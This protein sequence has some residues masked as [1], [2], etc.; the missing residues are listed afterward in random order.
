MVLKS[1]VLVLKKNSMILKSL[2][3]LSFLLGLCMTSFCQT[4]EQNLMKYWR[5]RGQLGQFILRGDGVVGSSTHGSYLPASVR[6]EVG[7]PGGYLLGQ[8][9]DII[10]DFWATNWPNLVHD[11]TDATCGGL[12]FGPDCT[13]YLGWYIGV[14]ATEY[15]LRMNY[16]TGI[17][18]Q[19]ILEE[20]WNALAA[21]ERLDRLAETLTGHPPSFNGYFLRDD[22]IFDI[23]TRDDN[24]DGEPNFPGIGCGIGSFEFKIGKG[25][26]QYNNFPS[27][28]YDVSI[29]DEKDYDNT[30]SG[31]QVKGLLMG[32][33]LVKA[34]VNPEATVNGESV[35]LKAQNIAHKIGKYAKEHD[36]IMKNANGE[37]QNDGSCNRSHLMMI[38]FPLAE[39]VN[40][41][42]ENNNQDLDLNQDGIP[43]DALQNYHDDLI[44]GLGAPGFEPSTRGLWKTI[45]GEMLTQYSIYFSDP[46]GD[47]P[48][49]GYLT[50]L[51]LIGP[52]GSVVI[53]AIVEA[54]SEDHQNIFYNSGWSL[55]EPAHLNA[56]FQMAAISNKWV[57]DEFRDAAHEVGMEIYPLLSDV[58]YN[59]DNM[60]SSCKQKCKQMIEIAPCDAF[61]DCNPNSDNCTETS[62]ACG[63]L[64]YV[65]V[66][67]WMSENRYEHKN[68]VNG[69]GNGQHNGLDFMLLYNLYHLKYPEELPST[70]F[71]DI[72]SGTLHTQED[73][74]I[75]QSWLS[76]LNTWT[77]CDGCQSEQKKRWCN[78]TIWSNDKV[79]IIEDVY[80]MG[81]PTWVYEPTTFIGDVEYRAGEEVIF[82]DG[83]EVTDGAQMHAYIDPFECEGGVLQRLAQDEEDPE[84]MQA[85]LDREANVKHESDF[86]IYPNPNFGSFTIAGRSLQQVIITDATGK[87]VRQINGGTR[88]Q[89]QI[90]GLSSGLYLVRAQMADGSVEN[91]KVVVQ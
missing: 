70:G 24:G 74:P 1:I 85:S 64:T 46:F 41:I 18:P 19:L 13:M 16:G 7:H 35:R 90:D 69:H 68:W 51:H 38:S 57:R 27:D 56:T 63:N 54:L 88:S 62:S 3:S 79:G 40:W 86:G 71:N 60:L 21:Y 33:A 32:M 50:P 72:Y 8:S 9:N 29:L 80:D 65:G 34:C 91:G 59:Q 52:L 76:N 78:G 75:A 17:D 11:G 30:P 23:A 82:F 87:L 81:P 22:V 55:E 73:L 36:Y 28:P 6:R 58:L 83:F 5:H 49:G 48:S 61:F 20:L 43:G 44:V 77:D 37:C 39:T 2:A 4:P 66:N 15:R 67:G 47:W 42:T 89:I 53:N 25:D 10:G 84:D 45:W 31:D 14:L 26:A 12:N